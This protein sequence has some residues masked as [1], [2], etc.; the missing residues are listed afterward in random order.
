MPIV[1]RIWENKEKTVVTVVSPRSFPQTQ[2]TDFR[3]GEMLNRT[4]LDLDGCFPVKDD[5]R[6]VRLPKV[7]EDESE[8]SRGNNDEHSVS[9]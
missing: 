3:Y 9:S 8:P 1:E 5:S 6:L 4:A 2:K 7:H